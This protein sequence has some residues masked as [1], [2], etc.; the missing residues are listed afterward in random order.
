MKASGTA[1]EE[2]PETTSKTVTDSAVPAE[3]KKTANVPSP[4]VLNSS[5]MSDAMDKFFARFNEPKADQDQKTQAKAPTKTR[6]ASLW[7]TPPE[8]TVTATTAPSNEKTSQVPTP[9]QTDADQ[10]GFARILQMLGSRSSN[11]TPQDQGPQKPKAPLYAKPDQHGVQDRLKSPDF[12]SMLADF[13][14]PQ[15]NRTA[16]VQESTESERIADSRSSTEGTHMRQES[17]P[18]KETSDILLNLMRQANLSKQTQ[19]D[20]FPSSE[21]RQAPSL[22]PL[23]DNLNRTVI[24]R[25][26]ITSVNTNREPAMPQRR[27]TG[28]SF[29][30]ESQIPSVNYQEEQGSQ[31]FQHNG[32]RRRPT[33]GPPLPPYFEPYL[34]NLRQN[35]QQPPKP[36]AGNQMHGQGLPPG[37]HRPPGLD[38]MPRMPPGWPNQQ[39]AQQQPPQQRQVPPPGIP[40]LP[41]GMPAPFGNPNPSM[42]MHQHL[43]Q[44]QLQSNQGLQRSQ[45]KYTGDSGPGFPPGMGPPP[46]FMNSGPPPGFPGAPQTYGRYQIGSEQQGMGRSYAEM[47]GTGQSERAI[48]RGVGPGPTGTGMPGAYR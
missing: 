3:A 31:D 29:F 28:S 39:Q 41:R 20:Q 33:S 5:E 13:D 32:L 48:V 40:N 17:G 26:N 27:E 7:N 24:S 11:S 10:A 1:T 18:S 45:R 16:R 37:L 6:F 46:G 12:G 34:A 22:I 44:Q 30:D 42:Q 23:V 43:Q 14:Q 4:T 15:R 19:Q 47:Y 2:K 38:T 35:E 36:L 8:P 9:S 25:S 21:L